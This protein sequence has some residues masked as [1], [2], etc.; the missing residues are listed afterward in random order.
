MKRS[1]L[2]LFALLVSFLTG[3]GSSGG[4]G[5]GSLANL[6]RFAGHWTMSAS[7]SVF[8]TLD[9]RNFVVLPEDMPISAFQFISAQPPISDANSPTGEM[10]SIYIEVLGRILPMRQGGNIAEPGQARLQAKEVL[11]LD[12]PQPA[13]VANVR[14]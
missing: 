6:E 14:R 5:R 11:R 7:F 9:G 8:T 3:C 12:R 10:W 2:V 13:F 4:G 1:L